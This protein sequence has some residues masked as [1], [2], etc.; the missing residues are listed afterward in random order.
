MLMKCSTKT[1]IKLKTNM[2]TL[3]STNENLPK[4]VQRKCYALF[5]GHYWTLLCFFPI[6][7]DW[8]LLWCS[9]FF[10]FSFLINGYPKGWKS[11]MKMCFPPLLSYIL[12]K[13]HSALPNSV[14]FRQFQPYAFR[15]LLQVP[16]GNFELDWLIFTADTFFSRALR[17]KQQVL[18][19]FPS[20]VN[21]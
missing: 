20:C 1:K 4:E 14:N 7:E 13:L 2:F 12:D 19:S 21:E 8:S 17:D 6:R 5:E 10:F 16:L 18:V 11:S 9:R 3:K 15:F